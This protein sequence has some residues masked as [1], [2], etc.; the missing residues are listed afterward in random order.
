MN[1]ELERKGSALQQDVTTITLFW[2]YNIPAFPVPHVRYIINWCRGVGLEALISILEKA[3]W[4]SRKGHFTSA[5]HC[6]R[7][8]SACVRNQQNAAR[9]ASPDAETSFLAQP[10]ATL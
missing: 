1:E 6:G 9:T 5:D 2:E 7:F 8:V 3:A 4:K 10:D